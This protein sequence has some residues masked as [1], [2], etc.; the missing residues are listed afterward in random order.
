MR[1]LI[2]AAALSLSIQDGLRAQTPD[3]D[4][5]GEWKL[6]DGSKTPDLIP[7]VEAWKILLIRLSDSPAGPSRNG[8]LGYMADSG[9]TV[10]ELNIV[11]DAANANALVTNDVLR[12]SQKAKAAST[13]PID[14]AAWA[15][16][17]APFDEIDA[18]VEKQRR[19]LETELSHEAYQKLTNFVNTRVKSTSISSI[20]VK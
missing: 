6:V 4:S 12:R 11:M 9:L 8:R 20:R 14:K 18:D 13:R 7:D 2:L 17:A 1:L 16:I 3:P 19:F 10:S 5:P 15:R